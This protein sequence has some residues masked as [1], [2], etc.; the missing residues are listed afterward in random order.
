MMGFES[1]SENLCDLRPPVHLVVDGLYVPVQVGL[2]GEAHVAQVARVGAFA[3]VAALM[4][5]AVVAPGEAAGAKRTQVGLQ[6]RVA[7]LFPHRL[8][9]ATGVAN[10]YI[11]IDGS[12][13]NALE[14]EKDPS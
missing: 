10:A 9:F 3:G 5:K 13:S 4:A 8:A 11:R 6:S 1:C 7:A 14:Q 2:D 12:F